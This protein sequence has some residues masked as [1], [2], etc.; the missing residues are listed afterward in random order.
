[1]QSS[2]VEDEQN[3]PESW[4]S[5]AHR[6]SI[7]VSWL[8][9]TVWSTYSYVIRANAV[10][11]S[12]SWCA[13]VDEECLTNWLNIQTMPST[14]QRCEVWAA[15]RSSSSSTNTKEVRFVTGVFGELV[16]LRMFTCTCVALISVHIYVQCNAN[17][18]Y[19][20]SFYVVFLAFNTKQQRVAA[21]V[22][23]RGHNLG[24]PE[25]VL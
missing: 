17:P 20:Y 8:S 3:S 4:K 5:L 14:S 18:W 12:M 21:F 19:K 7:E 1:M 6:D 15:C 2:G 22:S 13:K 9:S 16:Q 10:L 24:H 23:L 11:C 25:N